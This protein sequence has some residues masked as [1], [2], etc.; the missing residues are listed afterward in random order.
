MNEPT[1]NSPLVNYCLKES[2]LKCISI[3]HTRKI[4][5]TQLSCIQVGQTSTTESP[6]WKNNAIDDLDGY[7]DRNK[8]HLRFNEIDDNG[9]TWVGNNQDY[10]GLDWEPFGDTDYPNN[11]AKPKVKLFVWLAI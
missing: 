2:I 3:I 8:N 6:Y 7:S 11:Q 9:K 1:L 4:H 5:T 10:N